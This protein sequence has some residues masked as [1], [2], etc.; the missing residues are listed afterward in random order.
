MKYKIKDFIDAKVIMIY[1]L[2]KDMKLVINLNFTMSVPV[3]PNYSRDNFFVI[4]NP[5]PCE[6]GPRNEYPYKPT[7]PEQNNSEFKAI[8]ERKKKRGKRRGEMP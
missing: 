8:N 3:P 2:N 6:E 4:T 5:G 7:R 1:L